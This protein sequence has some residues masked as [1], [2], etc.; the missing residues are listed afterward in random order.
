MRLE[1]IKNVLNVDVDGSR[2]INHYV[3]KAMYDKID[4]DNFAT[5]IFK[6]V[7][8]F[9]LTWKEIEEKGGVGEINKQLKECYGV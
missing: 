7:E 5:T 8:E 2:G 3:I 9:D 6:I 1:F 4:E